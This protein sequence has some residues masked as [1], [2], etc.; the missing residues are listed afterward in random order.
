MPLTRLLLLPALCAAALASEPATP[1]DTGFRQM[2]NLQFPEAH[3]TF[4]EWERQH[5]TDPLGFASDAAAYLFA[6]FDRLH[7][8]QAEFFTHDDHFMTDH[9]L[10]PDPVAKAKFDQAIATAR[11]LAARQPNDKNAM[12][13]NVMAGGLESDYISLIDKRYRAAWKVM[14]ASRVDAETLLAKDPTY[15]DAWLAVGVENYMLSI[16]PL[17]I[18]LFLRAAGGETDRALGIEKLKLTA[19]KGH[20]LAPLARLLLAVAALR[21]GDVNQARGI[22]AALTQEYPKNPLFPQEMAR[23]SAAPRR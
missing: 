11:Q 5:P 6:E 14:K 13:A 16:K 23:L 4:R 19:T 21:D 18:R 8:L 2:Y 12:F 7:I 10:M 22:L 9:R 17:I 3:Q 15:Y 20:Y 1:L